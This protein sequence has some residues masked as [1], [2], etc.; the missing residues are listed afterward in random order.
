MICEV[1][2]IVH[3]ILAQT[4]DTALTVQISHVVPCPLTEVQH[5]TR[6]KICQDLISSVDDNPT[7]MHNIITDDKAWRFVYDP[8]TKGESTAW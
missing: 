7:F 4:N 5:Q 3:R 6:K 1:Q 2:C 8:Q